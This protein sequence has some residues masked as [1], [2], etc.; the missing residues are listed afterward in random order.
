MMLW[1][2]ASFTFRHNLT[3]SSRPLRMTHD[4]EWLILEGMR[5][6]DDP[7][8]ALSYQSV[9]LDTKLQLSPLPSSAETGVSLDVNQWRIL[10]QV[11][12]APNLRTICDATGITPDQAFR[13]VAELLAIGLVEIVPPVPQRLLPCPR[14]DL[15]SR[16][17][18]RVFQ[19]ALAGAHTATE[20][21][22]T[23][24]HSLLDAIMR[25]IHGL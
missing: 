8:R 11:S 23:V 13:T 12:S 7:A 24:S 9:T 25:R 10:S 5:R 6:C 16:S 2:N 15:E 22:P 17:A 14:T 3:V 20:G 18:G 19:S 1:D 4:S 21:T